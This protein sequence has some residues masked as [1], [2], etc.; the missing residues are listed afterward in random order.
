MSSGRTTNYYIPGS[1]SFF[2]LFWEWNYWE[3]FLWKQWGGRS[4]WFRRIYNVAK[5]NN[6][7]VKLLVYFELNDMKDQELKKLIE[8]AKNDDH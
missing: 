7:Y 3:K 5:Q 6:D 2:V 4:R 1:S 8:Y